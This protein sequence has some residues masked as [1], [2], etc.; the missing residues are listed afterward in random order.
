M[1]Q[2]DET[3]CRR[4]RVPGTVSKFHQDET[5]KASLPVVL[6]KIFFGETP[7]QRAFEP[8]QGK[9]MAVSTNHLTLR[10]GFD[11]LS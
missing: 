4:W 11:D 10:Y 9:T 2:P 7:K 8:R 6:D 3:F 5:R 1:F